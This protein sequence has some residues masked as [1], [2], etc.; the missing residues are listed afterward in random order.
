MEAEEMIHQPTLGFFK[1]LSTGARVLFVVVMLLIAAASAWAIYASTDPLRG[2]VESIAA[3]VSSPGEVM[4][5]TTT[6][7]YR[8]MDLRLNAY[9][10]DITYTAGPILPQPSLALIFILA[11]A[12]AWALY[13]TAATF[14]RTFW[15]YVAMVPFVLVWYLALFGNLIAPG[16]EWIVSGG[17][18][19]I[20]LV[21]AFALQNNL[22]RIPLL[23]RFLILLGI[24]VAPIA[25]IWVQNGPAAFHTS[26][27]SMYLP[28]A[29]LAIVWIV[30]IAREPTHLLLLLAT[31]AKDPKRRLT[32]PFL[33]GAWAVLIGLEFC[34]FADVMGLKW[35]HIHDFPF[36]P[37]HLLALA[38]MVSVVTLQN[39]HTRLGALMPRAAFFI[40]VG[41]GSLFMMATVAYYT[42]SGEHLFLHMIERLAAMVFFVFGVFHLFFLFY[43]FGPAFRDRKPVYWLAGAPKRLMYFF[44]VLLGVL[45][46]FS[47]DAAQGAKTLRF[48]WCTLYDL[49]GDREFMIGNKDSAAQF[50]ELASGEARTAKGNYNL[51]WL[52]V[53]TDEEKAREHFELAT[54]FTPFSLASINKADFEQHDGQLFSARTTLQKS[55]AQKP[56]PEVANNLANFW[57]RLGEP[58]SAITILKEGISIF[59]ENPVLY[60]TL[61]QIYLRHHRLDWAKASFEQALAVPEP[62]PAAVANALFFNLS[63][64]DSIDVPPALLSSPE[65]VANNDA[66]INHAL[67][68]YKDR[69]F[70][71]CQRVIDTL[72]VH[73]GTSEAALLDG[74]L[75][76]E[77]GQMDL[78]ISRME[79][80]AT[81]TGPL[82]S[83]ANHFLGVM[84]F[85]KGVPEMAAEYF[86]FAAEADTMQTVNYLRQAQM[87]I[88][89]GDHE[90]AHQ[91][92]QQLRVRDESLFDECNKEISMLFAANGQSLAAMLEYDLSRLTLEERVRISRYAGA[93]GR[94][95]VMLDNF[96]LIMDD[97]STSVL[98]QLEFAR[99]YRRNRDTSAIADVKGNLRYALTKD[100]KN[101]ALQ[102]ELAYALA[103]SGDL[104]EAKKTTASLDA[105]QVEGGLMALLKATISLAERDT[106]GA[107]GTLQEYMKRDRLHFEAN[108]LLAEIYLAQHDYAGGFQFVYPLVNE[109]NHQ[110]S[111]YWRYTAHFQRGMSD[112]E[113]A[114][115]SAVRAIALAR[116]PSQRELIQ[117]EFGAEIRLA[118]EQNPAMAQ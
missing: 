68:L 111:D 38:A 118:V 97:D 7:N 76:F 82:A 9:N 92:L 56:T 2:S 25:L 45:V 63:Y 33:I 39:Q 53:E 24:M 115:R 4:L 101:A 19:L 52:S 51:A 57:M 69:S 79:Y 22:L 81:T 64:G 96:R 27:V 94:Y 108:R 59:P 95:D 104:A 44:V 37:I 6:Q 62:H 78:A 3:T 13:L 5:S 67:R 110:N 35:V 75:K 34:M 98:P 21:F 100:P 89:M 105:N 40:G 77:R 18:I 20:L 31:N 49:E 103:V 17:W 70:D 14:L 30:I 46:G 23:P 116:I 66:M 87:V 28:L 72:L 29:M 41:G 50:Y 107:I 10:Q 1:Q 16:Q 47:M 93:I 90:G 73:N 117:K 84:Y 88:D 54:V 83:Q 32:S 91:M 8:T 86:G 114:G 71:S 80:I 58:D 43:N 113:A 65:V 12:V 60:V 99:I 109:L 102:A 55:W 74:M 106:A 26:S 112:P 61:G 11:Q 48:L 15:A 36:R 42:A 85:D